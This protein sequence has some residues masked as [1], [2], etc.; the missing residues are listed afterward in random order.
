MINS[1]TNVEYESASEALGRLRQ[2]GIRISKLHLSSALAVTPS[3]EN[4]VKL[5][6]YEEEVYLHQ[7][8]IRHQDESLERYRDL[9]PALDAAAARADEELGQEWRVHFHVPLHAAPGEPFR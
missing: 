4:L 1:L 6:S 7:V 8:I 3:R 9:T 5:R 2:A